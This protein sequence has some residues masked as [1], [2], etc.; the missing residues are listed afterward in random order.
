MG[1]SVGGWDRSVEMSWVRFQRKLGD[2]LADLEDGATAVVHALLPSDPEEGTGPFIRFSAHDRGSMIRA[3]V[4][5]NHYLSGPYQL[6]EADV[7][8][9]VA[10]GWQAPSSGEADDT[11]PTTDRSFFFLVEQPRQRADL[12][13]LMSVRA[14]R[15]AFGLPHPAFLQGGPLE[16]APVVEAES[17]REMR[18]EPEFDL[19]QMLRPESPEELDRFV[20]QTLTEILGREAYRDDDGDFPVRVGT[21][22]LFVR[23]L[24]TEPIIEVFSPLIRDIADRDHALLE[25]SI[26]NRDAQFISYHLG[27]STIVARMNVPAF[28]FVPNQ[29][30]VL[31]S[32]MAETLDGVDED[33]SLRVGGRLWLDGER[34][35]GVAGAPDD[36]DS[37]GGDAWAGDAVDE[38]DDLDIDDR[39]DRDDRDDLDGVDGDGVDA[40][41]EEELPPELL[42]LI[43]VDAEATDRQPPDVVAGLF[44]GDMHLVLHSLRLA[45]EQTIAWREST[46]EALA[47]DDEDEAAACAH[48]MRAWEKTVSDLRGAL[49]LIVGRMT[50]GT[51]TT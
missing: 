43:Q 6:T 11:G 8:E 7:A 38:A 42:A 33:L 15:D 34:T 1:D 18:G 41:E 13:A 51:W 49:R 50:P 2:F 30:A 45:E 5:S 46:Q 39:D 9:L 16:P 28:P 47:E 22:V 12:V 19:M 21:V 14:L 29:L 31:L 48:E 26:L 23:P 20:A 36:G 32:R 27:G 40:E 4:A 44:H 3:E 37:W 10:A 25:V 24:A 17:E 35:S